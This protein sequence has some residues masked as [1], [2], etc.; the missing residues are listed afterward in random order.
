MIVRMWMWE[1]ECE[2]MNATIWMSG[3]E[4]ETVNMN[5]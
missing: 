5:M 2:N 3:G 1:C 4:N